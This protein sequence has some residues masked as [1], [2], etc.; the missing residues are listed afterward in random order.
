MKVK[1]FHGSKVI[2]TLGVTLDTS[3]LPNGPLPTLVA[4]I[5]YLT[6]KKKK[7]YM[8]NE[9]KVL[10]KHEQIGEKKIPSIFLQLIL[11]KEMYHSSK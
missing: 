10:K 5:S 2:N 3:D 1:N 11:F 6:K 7:N 9:K 4:K 8:K